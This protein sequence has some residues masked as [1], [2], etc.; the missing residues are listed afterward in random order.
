MILR[1]HFL[2]ARGYELYKIGSL[3]MWWRI[4]P[5]GVFMIGANLGP[6]RFPEFLITKLADIGLSVGRLYDLSA[7]NVISVI[8]GRQFKRTGGPMTPIP[9][10]V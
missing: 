7:T 6:Q 9:R 10:L 1:K 3:A 4:A 2:M 5:N 8:S